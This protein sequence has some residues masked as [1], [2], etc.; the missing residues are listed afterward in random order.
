MNLRL[1]FVLFIIAPLFLVFAAILAVGL[2]AF[3]DNTRKTVA[4]ELAQSAQLHAARIEVLLHEVAQIAN[5]TAAHLSIDSDI[6]EATAFDILRSNVESSP[7]VFGAALAFE[8]DAFPGRRLFGPYVYRR[9]KDLA[10]IVS[11]ELDYD[12]TRPEWDW[13]NLPR[14]A[15][16]NIWT[17]PYFDEGGGNIYM[18]TFSAP[19]FREG[20]FSGVATIDIPLEPLKQLISSLQSGQGQHFMLLSARQRILYS[21][22]AEDIGRS[23]KDVFQEL[24]RLDVVAA[25]E[26]TATSGNT[27]MLQLQGW[28]SAST[29]WISPAMIESGGWMLLSIQDEE[30]ALA[31]LNSQKTKAISI[32]SAVFI[33]GIVAIWLLLNWV[34]RPLGNLTRAV[35][36][37]GKGNMNIHI[38]RQSGDEIGDL[39]A[40][41]ANMA[42]QLASREAA[43]KELNENLEKRVADRTAKLTSLQAGLELARDEAN[44]ANQAKSEFLANMSHELRTP[45]NAILGYSEM[46]IEDAGEQGQK[47]FIPDLNKI[48]KAGIHLLSLIN[49]VLDLAKI[50]SGKMEAY[51]EKFSL[52]SLIDDVSA[53]AHPLMEKNNNRMSIER[54]KDLGTAWQDLTKLR[55]TLFNLISNAAK[56]THDG[57]VTLHVN[58]A[59]QDGQDWLTLAVSDTG[60]GIAADKIEHVFEKFA[61]ADES[62]TRDYGG[63]GLGLA[64][65]RR[66]CNLLGGDLSVHS[67]VGK[68]STFTIRIPVMLPEEK[69]QIFANATSVSDAVGV[70]LTRQAGA[71]STILVIDDDPE[72]R[73]IIE[74]FLVKDGFS[75]VTA[76]SGEQGLRIARECMPAAITLDV[77]MPG[78]DGWSFLSVLKAD[79]ELR[80][81]PV[82]M[83]TMIDDRSRGY[84][85]GAVDYLTKPVDRELL[86]RAL[87]RYNC[88]E[89]AGQVLLVEDD[90]ESRELMAIMLEKVGWSVSEAANGQQALDMMPAIHP[91]LILLDLM[92]PVMDGFGF[93]AAM[94]AHP[95]WEHIPVIVITAKDLTAEDRDRLTGRVEEVF[96]KNAC[97]REQLLA[98]VRAAVASCS[99][100]AVA[101]DP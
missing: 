20:R 97:T 7:L 70:Q 45:M 99:T 79:P 33:A 21:D 95:E 85:L 65:S 40:S 25:L 78:M 100:L 89:E 42:R 68:G 17:E 92:M 5:T 38:E 61:Q 58:R 9:G 29:Q 15:Q 83:L 32:L 90:V 19:F 76:D 3:E 63:T 6:D 74:R 37:V 71:V 27:R 47:E 30:R 52:D 1:K 55:Q 73:E 77:M 2:Q 66:F 16:A 98:Q 8:P 41:F 59:T 87:N 64:I 80:G 28:D 14:E 12:Y 26:Q 46:L 57:A 39:A 56:F 101:A 34:T 75:V 86:H 22:N 88:G 44:A 67:E 93:L 48:N 91:Q 13:W 96:E 18:T 53:T 24:G 62:T 82:I 51:A 94:R 11:T 10:E 35:E 69:P 31:F 54:G 72:A 81:I 50:E 36:E 49:D 4:G 23:I 60:I 84:S 43:L